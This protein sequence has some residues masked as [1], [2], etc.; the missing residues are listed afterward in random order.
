MKVLLVFAPYKFMKNITS[1]QFPLGLGYLAAYLRSKDIEVKIADL[2][3]DKKKKFLNLLN[4]Y[5]PDIVGISCMTPNQNEAYGIARTVKNSLKNSLVILGG[6]HA[7][8][9]YDEILRTQKDIDIVAIGEGEITLFELCRAHDDGLSIT[10]LSDIRGIAFR[11]NGN[12]VVT[13]ARE[14]IE[15]PDDLPWPA[16]DLVALPDIETYFTKSRDLP[17]LTSRGCPFK[18]AFCSTSVMHGQKYRKREPA[19][20]VDELEYFK[21][22]F[23]IKSFSIVD[24]TFTVDKERT[25]KICYDIIRRNLGINWGCSARVDTLSPDMIKVMKKAGCRGLFFGIESLN[26]EIL[27]KI[28]KGFTSKK[29]VRMVKM[30]LEEGLIVDTS[31][32][33]G[34]PGDNLK[35]TGK[36]YDFV[37]K[38]K[39]NGRVLTN[40]LQ[41]LPGTDMYINPDNYGIKYSKHYKSTW[42]N[43]V[44]FAKDLPFKELLKEKIRIQYAHYENQNED[45]SLYEIPYP[46]VNYNEKDLPRFR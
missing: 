17:V 25:K 2:R 45:S 4:E 43:S 7:T 34:L 11:N 8:F 15:N 28:K 27:K 39:I 13:P 9:M 1:N 32:I 19:K 10:K 20:I 22:K 30:A 16:F 21:N 35:N 23:N 6:V 26:D 38:Y 24:D 40:T 31:F 3:H 12:I 14:K 29:A 42:A 41:I 5:N 44:S 37:K 46:A 18:C 33:L 36:I